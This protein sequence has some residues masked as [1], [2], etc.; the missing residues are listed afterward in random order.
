MPQRVAFWIYYQ[1]VILIAKGAR[2]YPKPPGGD[3]KPRVA[4][5]GA[6]KL[7]PPGGGGGCPYEWTDTPAWPWYL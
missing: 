1:A 5:E 4:Q 7:R 6:G 3:F 2:I